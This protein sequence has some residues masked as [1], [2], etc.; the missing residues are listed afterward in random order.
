MQH[1]GQ[2][3]HLSRYNRPITSNNALFFSPVQKQQHPVLQLDSHYYNQQRQS[4]INYFFPAVQR[5]QEN[6]LSFT[7]PSTHLQNDDEELHL[8]NQNAFLDEAG[9]YDPAAR[10]FFNRYNG[11]TLTTS[12]SNFLIRT[13]T[14]ASLIQTVITSTSTK[15]CVPAIEFSGSAY[16]TTCSANGRR[17]RDLVSLLDMLQ[18]VKQQQGRNADGDLK[19]EESVI[20]PYAVEPLETTEEPAAGLFGS[21]GGRVKKE[22]SVGNPLV[23]N[24]DDIDS[25]K[26]TEE[27]DG[28]DWDERKKRSFFG[29]IGNLF[30]VSST[31][32]ITNCSTTIT[33]TT[34]T[35]TLGTSGAVTCLPS[36]L[37]TC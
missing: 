20:S 28:A 5:V 14:V 6:R 30:L 8:V 21:S 36:G 18:D 23:N 34:S 9:I 31:V 13:K 32:S 16:L 33:T 4:P 15:F 17:R 35:L 29:G 27:A 11:I 25:S 12:S 7:G 3:L 22:L 24:N 2:P 10:S 1:H 26:N 37:T 19:D